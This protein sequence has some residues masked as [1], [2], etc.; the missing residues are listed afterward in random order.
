MEFDRVPSITKYLSVIFLF[1]WLGR[2]TVW[3]FLPIYFEQHVSSVFLI[4]VMTSLPALVPIFLDIPVGNLVQRAGERLVLF[5]GILVSLL[6][7]IMYITAFPALLVFG[8]L[9]EGLAKGLIWNAGWSLNMKS[10]DE[11]VESE[12]ISV[13]FLGLNLAIVIGPIIGGFLIASKGFELPFILWIFTTVLGIALY[14]FYVGIK[15]KMSFMESLAA[16]E[17]RDTY[18]D[19]WHHLKNNWSNLKE[20]FGLVFL[21]SIIFSFYWLAVPLL[22]DKV[23]A[24][25]TTMGIIFGLS[26]VPKLF[27]FIFGEFADRVGKLRAV[28]VLSTVLVIFLAALSQVQSIILLGGLFFVARALSG[29]LSPAIHAFYDSRV[30]DDIESELTGFF[31]LA[32]HIGQ[33]SGPIMAG[34]ISDLYG[35]SSSF[36]MAA[37][38]ALAIAVF[39]Y[40]T[41]R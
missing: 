12:S 24:D 19:D 40:R 3:N 20:P 9:F 30:P 16:L 6:P 10:A 22:L 38:I 32:K 34:A 5:L 28:T 25:Y 35:V 26:L 39:S 21:Y 2:S 4:G 31:E 11:E 14:Y 27:Q 36:L 18:L 37:G 23:N 13:F 1:V 8:K 15:T 33:A 29:G 41:S 17:R 7:P